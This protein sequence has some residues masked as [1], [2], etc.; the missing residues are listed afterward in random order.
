MRVNKKYCIIG[1][2]LTLIL[3]VGIFF[4]VVAGMSDDLYHREP[5]F[6]DCEEKAENTACWVQIPQED[7]V[8]RM[9]LSAQLAAGE[10]MELNLQVPQTAEYALAITYQ[11][12]GNTI[13]QGTITVRAGG[14]EVKSYINGIW[15]DESKAYILDRYQ[16][17]VTPSQVKV[18]AYV[19]DYI[20]DC[21]TLN[22][23]PVAFSLEAGQ[24]TV[25]I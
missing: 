12:V 18:D 16:N 11:T 19:T 25:V 8:E 23:D 1:I 5:A 21:T 7:V 14:S 13:V 20:R 4:L 10:R 9:E 6:D 3:A 15:C 24:Q 2:V 17:E 22:L